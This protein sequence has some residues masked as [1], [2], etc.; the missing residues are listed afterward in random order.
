MLITTKFI[1]PTNARGS[2]VKATSSSG[3][4]KTIDWQH[5]LN[6]DDNHAAAAEALANQMIKDGA[7]TPSRWIRRWNKDGSCVH[8]GIYAN[9]L[10]G[11]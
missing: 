8:V 11:E 1:G 5:A 7:C 4:T 9:E 2:R 10:K 6:S 3:K